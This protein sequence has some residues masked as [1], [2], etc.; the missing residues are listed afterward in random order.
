[1]CSCYYKAVRG[2]LYKTA[3][4]LVNIETSGS[5]VLYVPHVVLWLCLLKWFH[6][7]CELMV[8]KAI[9][10]ADAMHSVK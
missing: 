10:V 8:V 3:D 9:G 7:V 6:T 2:S 4:G 1:M 5:K